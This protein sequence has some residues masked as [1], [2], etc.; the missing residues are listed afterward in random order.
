[1][2]SRTAKQSA[3]D[4]R[5]GIVLVVIVVV[6]AILALVVAGAVRPVRDEAELATLRVETTRAFYAAESGGF[7]VMNAMMGNIDMPVASSS[8]DLGNQMVR[9]V[10]VPDSDPIA[11]V[12]GLS[13]DAIR[14]IEL[15]TE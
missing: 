4:F 13:G 9:F 10:Q 3:S 12:E 1:M 6:M 11:V 14:R 5:R 2:N 15:T 8:L 7:I